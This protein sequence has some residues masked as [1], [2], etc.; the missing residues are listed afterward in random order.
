[1]N[2]RS[3]SIVADV[4]GTHVRF[5]LLGTGSAPLECVEVF[6]CAEFARLDAALR[7]YLDLLTERLSESQRIPINVRIEALCFALPGP[8]HKDEVKLVNNPWAIN[9]RSLAQSFACPVFFLNDF[10]A[11]AWALDVLGEDD[12]QWLRAPLAAE[13][14]GGSKVVIGPGTGLGVAARLESGAVLE[15]EAGHINFAP[16]SDLQLQILEQL[17]RLYPAV[18]NERLA[19]GPGLANIHRALAS[20]EGHDLNLEPAEITARAKQGDAI[21]KAS[22]LEFSRIFGAVCGDLCLAYGATGGVYLSGGVLEKLSGLFDEQAFLEQFERKG[23]FQNYCHQIPIARICSEHPG[24]IGA[25]Q[26]LRK[27]LSGSALDV[28]EK[29]QAAFSAAA[30]TKPMND[31]RG[32]GE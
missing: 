25:A 29:A 26:F 11:Q 15:T 20:I 7:H 19:S 4:G 9:R 13:S 16:M 14:A 24:L 5:A 32:R 31:F 22:I 28:F 2:R 1:M 18:S 6:R 23:R 8:V 3:C 12:L 27:Q 10:G 21:C 30:T 17:R